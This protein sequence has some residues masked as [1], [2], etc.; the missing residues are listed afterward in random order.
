MSTNTPRQGLPG[1]VLSAPA[2]KDALGPKRRKMIPDATSSPY[3]GLDRHLNRKAP[4]G[5]KRLLDD[6]NESGSPFVT[7]S[8]TQQRKPVVNIVAQRG[9]G[10]SRVVSMDGADLFGMS[11]LKMKVES[12]EPKADIRIV[13]LRP[14]TPDSE[15]RA[16]HR[17]SRLPFNDSYA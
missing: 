14:A 3:F 8:A 15:R 13:D 17:T 2:S 11:P 7:T 1:V 10:L 5:R 16:H 12:Q 4:S 6:L 9:K